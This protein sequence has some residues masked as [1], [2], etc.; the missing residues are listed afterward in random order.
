MKHPEHDLQV[1]C[2]RWFRLQY[3]ELSLCLFAIPNGGTRRNARE[4]ARLKA[5]GVTAGVA[6]LE[7]IIPSPPYHG[8][9]IEMKVGRNTQSPAQRAFQ[10]R[11][12]S[13]G[14]RYEV[15]TSLEQFQTLIREYLSN[16]T[17]WDAKRAK[18]TASTESVA[19]PIKRP[20][21]TETN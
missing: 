13:K 3:Q 21:K 9:F 6:D 16:T 15:C 18:R 20:K 10:E 19:L 7:L 17:G 11:A 12:I 8:L 4:G 5:E 2:V 1:A 14:Y